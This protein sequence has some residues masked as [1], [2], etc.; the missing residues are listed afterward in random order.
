[1]NKNLVGKVGSFSVDNLIAKLSPNAETFGVT[2][3]KEASEAITLVRGTVLAKSNGTAGDG[4]LV[5][6]GTAAVSNETLVPYAILADDVEVGT[7]ADA[8]AVAYRCGNFNRGAIVVKSGYTMT[9]ADEDEL[10]KNDIIF[11]DAI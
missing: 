6:L 3:R 1:M 9:G 8:V 7:D 2:I 10:R 11:T 4:K 5:I